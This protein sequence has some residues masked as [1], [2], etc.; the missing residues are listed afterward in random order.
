MP[1]TLVSADEIARPF[2]DAVRSSV[3]SLGAHVTLRG[4]LASDRRASEVYAQYTRT[5]CEDVGIRFDLVA[6]PPLEVERAIGAANA[7]P[8]VHGV[9]MYYPVFG[10]ERDRT[11]QDEV[12]SEKDVE[13]LSP[14]WVRLLYHDVRTV[15]DGAKKTVLPCTPLAIVKAFEHVGFYARG[16]AP[17]TQ[18]RGRTVVVFN[19]SEVVGRP[20]AAMLAHD[21]AR[22]FSFDLDGCLEYEGAAV[23]QSQATRAQALAEADAVV[24]GVPSRDFPLVR[25]AEIKPG[26]VCVNFSTFKNMADDILDRASVFLPRVGPI[27]V[28]MLLRNTLRLYENFHR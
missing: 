19:R 2:R 20:L 27:T 24:T 12:D 11:L 6:V 25:A 18:A 13:G 4:I 3:A 17:G 7:D 28:A 9:M 23:R 16:A 10:G 26:A 8:S 14:R 21:G 1:G 15:G 5:G 22:V